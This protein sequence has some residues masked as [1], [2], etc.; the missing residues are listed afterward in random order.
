MSLTNNETEVGFLQKTATEI[1]LVSFIILFQ[2]LVLIRWLPGQVRVLAY[3]PNLILISAFLGLGV[4]CLRA[5]RRSLLWLWPVSLSVLVGMAVVMSHIAFTQN[6]VTEHLWLL[7]YN[8]PKNAPVIGTVYPPII[9]GF[10]LGIITFIPLGQILA[11]RLN[12]FQKISS[13]LWGY[14]WNLLGSLLGVIAFSFIG[15]W[16]LFPFIWFSVLLTGGLCFFLPEKKLIV[17]LFSV[18]IILVMVI[19]TEKARHYSPYYAIS[20]EHRTDKSGFIVMTNG[21]LHQHALPLQNSDDIGSEWINKAR[22]GY[23]FPY[24]QLKS[25]PKRVL[26]LGSGTGN[27]VAVLLDEGVEHI[28]AVEIDPII[29]SLGKKHPNHPYNSEKV[30]IIN[31]DARNYLNETSETYDLVVFGTLDSM[32]KLSALSNVRLDNFVY[33]LECIQAARSHLVSGGGIVLYFMAATRYIDDRL[34]GMLAATFNDLPVVRTKFSNLFNRIYMAGPCFSHIYPYSQQ[35]RDI[36]F[37]QKLPN[38]HL[39]SD[40]WPYLYLKSKGISR[41]YLFLIA[42]FIGVAAICVFIASRD[43]RMSIATMQGID[44]EMFFFGL[45]FLLI[46]TKFVTTMN[47]IWG[48]TWLTSAIVFGAVLTM[49]LLSTVVMQLKPLKWGT[50]AV[51]LLVS[52]LVTYL[53]PSYY[54]LVNNFF[55]KLMLSVFFIGTPI[56]FASACFAL[57]F[58]HRKAVDVAFGWNLLGAVVGGLLEFLSMVIGL[59]S[60]SLLAMMAYLGAFWIREQ[61]N[62]PAVQAKLTK[63][64]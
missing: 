54:L 18:V 8:L 57:R 6:S 19:Q 36:Y 53:I 27:D 59:K 43:M 32:T 34:F 49:L 3:F 30:R 11:D 25:I 15:F 7:Y 44:T 24:R 58:K 48:A 33:T 13:P 28:D 14:S 12:T 5:G 35:Q 4:G 29:L 61:Y 31:T 62:K 46:E 2:E 42:V 23:H 16:G 41:F 37:E 60:L 55:I 47:L 56:F 63:L 40:D 52:L 26:I 38:I 20:T 50:A 21:S 39:P 10:L 9:I 64:E 17:Y 22:E 45:A 51:G 1:L